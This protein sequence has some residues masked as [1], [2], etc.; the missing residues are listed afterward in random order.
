[1]DCRYIPSLTL[2][3]K[4]HFIPILSKHKLELENISMNIYLYIHKISIKT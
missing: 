1:M 3:Y 2:Y 4:I